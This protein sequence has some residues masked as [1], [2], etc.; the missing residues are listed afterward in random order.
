MT[1]I[2]GSQS[3]YHTSSSTEPKKNQNSALYFICFPLWRDFL[4][5]LRK[6]NIRG[7]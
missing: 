3:R 5:F 4:T 1:Y 2:N 7:P 6:C